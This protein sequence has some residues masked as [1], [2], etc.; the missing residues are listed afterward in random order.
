MSDDQLEEQIAA[1]PPETAEEILRIN[2]E[3]R[4][5]ALQIALLVPLLASLVGLPLVP[6]DAPA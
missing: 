6:D 1:Q 4:P 2:D 5:Q 3:A